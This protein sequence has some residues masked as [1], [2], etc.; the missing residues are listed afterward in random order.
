[1]NGN[2]IFFD[3]SG[4]PSTGMPPATQSYLLKPKP[5]HHA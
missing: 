2:A 1:M 4:I 3:A 5:L